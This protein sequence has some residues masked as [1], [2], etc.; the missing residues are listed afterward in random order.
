MPPYIRPRLICSGT[1]QRV[2][3]GATEATASEPARE[4]AVVT[5]LTE[6]GGFIEV[7]YAADDLLSV[8]EQGKTNLRVLVDVDARR[9]EGKNGNT[10]AELQARYAGEAGLA[11]SPL[12]KVS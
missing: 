1:A 9:Y 6:A 10:Y 12:S 7:Y 2:V 3:R 4:Y 11:A 8:P 5:V